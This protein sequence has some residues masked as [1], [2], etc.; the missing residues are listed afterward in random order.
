MYDKELVHDL[1][2]QILEAIQKI[3]RRF[4]SISAACDFTDTSEGTDR[5]DAICMMLIAIGESIKNIDKITGKK[6]F[7]RYP[8][9]D[10]KG[11]KGL[12]D[13][14]SHHYFDIDAEQ[15]FWVCK[16]QLQPLSQTIQKMMCS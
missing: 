3:E 9:I 5:M 10:W 14:I 4:E 2:G 1:L 7:T 15:I 8:E 11:V 6:L 16:N 13:I 12:R